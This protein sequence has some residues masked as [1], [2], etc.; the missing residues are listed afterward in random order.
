MAGT[1]EHHRARPALLP[2]QDA[3]LTLVRA[4]QDYPAIAQHYGITAG[5]AYLIA[6]GVP[7]D[8]SDGLSPEDLAREGLLH[9]SSQHLAHPPVA[10][11]SQ[12]A[13]VRNFLRAR[14]NADAQMQD[15]ARR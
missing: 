7:C 1:D 3:V 6:T 5:L 11:R 10:E 15:A 8:S 13:V 9:G 14:A 4:G 12:G 2:T